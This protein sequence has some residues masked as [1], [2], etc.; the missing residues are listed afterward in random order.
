M[1]PQLSRFLRRLQDN[2]G[3]LVVPVFEHD[4]VFD[5]SVCDRAEHLRLVRSITDGGWGIG[6]GYELTRRGWA[7]V[8]KPRRTPKEWVL[9]LIGR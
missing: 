8:G 3:R 7:A 2:N 4:D 5:E 9:S 6:M 1:D